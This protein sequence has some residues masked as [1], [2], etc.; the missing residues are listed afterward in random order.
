MPFFTKPA[1]GPDAVGGVWPWNSGPIRC[2]NRTGNTLIKGKVI[3]L[4]FEAANNDA[5][6]IATNDSNSY[7]PG[8]SNDTVWNTVVDPKANAAITGLPGTKIGGIFGVCLSD[9]VADNTT[10]DFQFWGLVDKAF[11]VD[12]GDSG[13]GAQP[14]QVLGVT[15]TNSFNCTVGTNDVLVGFYMSP[16]AATLSNTPVL[17]R[18]FLTNGFGLSFNGAQTTGVNLT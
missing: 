5:T 11:V 8:F 2:W 6:E 9:S 3:M 17:K 13:D 4:A 18:V 12:H 10:G 7:V 15:T 1:G 16:S 14:G